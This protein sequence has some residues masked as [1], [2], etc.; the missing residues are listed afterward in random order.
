MFP[1]I[2]LLLAPALLPSREPAQ[3]D[4]R[5]AALC[6]RLSWPRSRF[7][8]GPLFDLYGTDGTSVAGL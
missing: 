7:E 2:P 1:T 4:Q 6:H 5:R 8:T 3:R